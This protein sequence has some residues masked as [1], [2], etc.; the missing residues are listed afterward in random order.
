MA[1][2]VTVK[3]DG[4][5]EVTVRVVVADPPCDIATLEGLREAVRPGAD[6]V[7][8]SVTVP[9]K[10]LTPL[11]VIVEF[12]L[13]PASKMIDEGVG[14]LKS[15][16]FTVMVV[17]W[18]RGPFVPITVTIYCPGGEAP[19]AE[20]VSVERTVL[21]DVTATLL[22]LVVRESPPGAEEEVKAT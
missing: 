3:V 20:M 18:E 22:G 13:A 10:P 9:E 15:T 5:E 1:V 12:P 16:T 19:V 4:T 8:A 17:E 7:A 6:T 14:M 21:P 2:M 11:T